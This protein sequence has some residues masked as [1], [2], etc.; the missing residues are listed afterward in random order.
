MRTETEDDDEVVRDGESVRVSA[1]LMDGVQRSMSH[2]RDA[3]MA[4]RDAYIQ[5]LNNAWRTPL[6]DLAPPID[7]SRG[8]LS[9]ETD[10]DNAA[11]RAYQSYKDQLANA[12]R[13][14]PNAATAIERQAESWRGG[15]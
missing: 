1:F 5:Q 7:P 6:R 12:W 14:D 2:G 3:R 4:A 15:R 9:R 8:P 11:D 10:P 13:A